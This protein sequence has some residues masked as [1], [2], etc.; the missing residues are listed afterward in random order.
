MA[1]LQLGLGTYFL[2]AAVPLGWVELLCWVMGLV[3]FTCT[4]ELDRVPSETEEQVWICCTGETG[5]EE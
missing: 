2:L 1:F 4:F 5:M 3:H